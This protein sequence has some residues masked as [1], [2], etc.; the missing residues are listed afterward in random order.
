MVRFSLVRLDVA[1][2]ST[3][4]EIATS[5]P[6]FRAVTCVI[7][8]AEVEASNLTQAQPAVTLQRS[9]SS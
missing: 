9:S 3:T 7:L 5:V 4:S 8:R 1:T 2:L 6:P